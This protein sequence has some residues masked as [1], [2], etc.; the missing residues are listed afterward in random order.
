MPQYKRPPIVEAII[1]IRLEQ[2]LSQD[3]V[4]GVLAR[5]KPDYPFSDLY[6]S[7]SVELDVPGRRA[8]YQEESSGYRLAS[9]DR[10]DVLLV[11]TAYI[12][13]ARLAPY[14]GWGALRARAKAHWVTWKQAVGHRK[15]RRI[16]VRYINR[17]DI[18]ATT[19]QTV[20]IETYLRVYPETGGM[21][22]MTS[23]SMQVSGPLD[24]DKCWLVVNSRLVPSPLV[25]HASVVLDIDVSRKDDVPQSDDEMWA[26]IDRMRMHKNKI[27]E[28]SITDRARELFNT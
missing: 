15:V 10:A 7:G 16:G 6:W 26:L 17:I 23:Y 14:L 20:K 9:A 28:W 4:D 5:F 3:E 18:P 22:T 27:F 11:T 12:S 2:P 1:E 19:E 8:G 13:C 24:D 21:K 25:D